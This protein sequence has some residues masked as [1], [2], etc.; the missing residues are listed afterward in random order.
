MI[1]KDVRK[2]TA[3]KITKFRMNGFINRLLFFKL[4]CNRNRDSPGYLRDV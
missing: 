1:S 4:L 2:T 3:I